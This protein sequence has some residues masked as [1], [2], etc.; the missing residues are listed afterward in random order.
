MQYS[1]ICFEKTFLDGLKKKQTQFRYIQLH[2]ILR[3]LKLSEGDAFQHFWLDAV[4]HVDQDQHQHTREEDLTG[5]G[6]GL[7]LPVDEVFLHECGEVPRLLAHPELYI[8][9]SIRLKQI[10]SIGQSAYISNC[11][12]QLIKYF[13]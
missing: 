1:L 12:L 3:K 8:F 6:A 9:I 4:A 2:L 10:H 11:G 5:S 7:S 13:K